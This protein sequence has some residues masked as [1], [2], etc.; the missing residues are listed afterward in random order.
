MKN[1]YKIN[2][3]NNLLSFMSSFF[4][5]AS[6]CLT[7]S[8]FG[9]DSS[10]EKNKCSLDDFAEY[11]SN[12]EG[13]HRRWVYDD[14]TGKRLFPGQEDKGNRTI[15]VGFNLERAGAEEDFKKILDDPDFKK[16]YSGKECITVEQSKK[17]FLED[18]SKSLKFAKNTF[19]DFPEYTSMLQKA[20][21]DGAYRGDMRDS[22]KTIELINEGKFKLAAREYSC[23]EEYENAIKENQR[24][25]IRRI[26]TNRLAIFK[27]VLS[28]PGE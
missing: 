25:L 19:P 6:T 14:A 26:Q 10:S 9:E 28:K 20:L 7:P 27:E 13:G 18:I 21:V 8:L 4:L 11:T 3:R 23:R 5:A 2:K 16:V 15:G 12:F 22:P 24:G 1:N 17:L